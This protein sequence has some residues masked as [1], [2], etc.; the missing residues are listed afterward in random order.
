VLYLEDTGQWVYDPRG[1]TFTDAVTSNLGHLAEVLARY[2][3]NAPWSFRSPDGVY[4]G[5][6]G[7][8]VTRFCESADLFLNVSGCCW[9]RDSYRSAKRKIYLDTDPGYSHAKLAAAERGIANEDEVFSVN[10]IRAHDLFFTFAENMGHESCRLPTAGLRWQTTRQP[11]VLDDW[12]YSYRRDAAAYTTVMSWKTDVTLPT[13][14]GIKY[15][16][17]DIE[18]ARFAE[19]PKE[20]SA[21]LEI[22]MAGVAP[23][24]ELR[25][26][27]WLVVEAGEKSAT[28]DDYRAYLASSRGE[29]SV[30]KNAY[31]ATNSGWFS[32]R[33]ACYLALGKP[34]VVQDTGFSSRYPTGEGLFAFNTIDQAAAALETIE[35]DYRRHCE[36]ARSIA[37]SEFASEKVLERLCRDAGL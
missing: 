16:G 5:V 14:D 19:L 13:I 15:G 12:P 31:V 23:R 10:L 25:R 30:A 27:G 34:V 4:H 11:I 29:W 7:N 6:E 17:K 37:E 35:R 22:A 32:C 24:D 3:S 20:T 28:M 36:A 8:Q 21:A 2:A 1:G 9:L 18:F 33:S 26:K